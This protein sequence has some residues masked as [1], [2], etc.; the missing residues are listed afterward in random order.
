MVG[1]CSGVQL[2]DVG[3]FE[4]RSWPWQP[5]SGGGAASSSQGP[6]I[7]PGAWSSALLPGRVLV[8]VVCRGAQPGDIRKG[9]NGTADVG[10]LEERDWTRARSC[11]WPRKGR[12]R[13]RPQVQVR[14]PIIGMLQVCGLVVPSAVCRLPSSKGW[15]PL[16]EKKSPFARLDVVS[17]SMLLPP[18]TRNGRQETGRND[19]STLSADCGRW[20]VRSGIALTNFKISDG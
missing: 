19:A 20:S 10:T 4:E 11:R 7:N 8:G 16:K 18:M 6:R 14:L 17:L 1:G 12:S 9:T 2:D 15:I 5:S 3:P 13:D